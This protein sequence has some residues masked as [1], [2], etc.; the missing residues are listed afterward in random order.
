MTDMM[1]RI[2]S[3]TETS[4][5]KEKGSISLYEMGAAREKKREVVLSSSSVRSAATEEVSEEDRAAF[6]HEAAEAAEA[7]LGLTLFDLVLTDLHLVFHI[8][9]E[10]NHHDL[11]A[12]T[13]CAQSSVGSLIEEFTWPLSRANLQ[14]N[15]IPGGRFD[16]EFALQVAPITSVQEIRTDDYDGD[17]IEVSCGLARLRGFTHARFSEILTELS[18]IWT[19][20]LETPIRRHIIDPLCQAAGD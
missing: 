20:E 7:H 18:S 19:D 13:L 6:T 16:L 1:G 11:V 10:G 5:S 15:T 17:T 9:Y 12:R 4:T 3:M 2:P 14:I 8:E